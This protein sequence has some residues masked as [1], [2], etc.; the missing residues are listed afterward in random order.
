M[1]PPEVDP[2][3]RLDL[4]D[5]RPGAVTAT[6]TGAPTH[7]VR[8][9][10]AVHGFEPLDD[11]TMVMAR[12]DRE[13]PHYAELAARALRAEG[14]T[15]DI[16]PQ[17]REEIDTEWTWANYPMPWCSREEIREV[18]NDAQ[19]IYDDI[20]SG[21][22]II[23]A[24]AHDG[25]TTVAVGTYR[26]GP[27]IHLHGVNHLRVE[28]GRYDTPVKAIA[29]FERLY[30]DA[31][32]HGPAPAT[33][34]ERDAEQARTPSTPYAADAQA[35]PA[36][37]EPAEA[38]SAS[39]DD[40]EALLKDFLESQGEWECWRTW[41]DDTTHA[42]HESLVLRAEF[43]HE[44]EPTGT[45]WKIAAYESP[46]GERVWHATA[47]T[48]VPVEIMQVVLDSL[49]SAD[50]VE[51]AEGNQISEATIGEATRPLAGAGWKHTIDGRAIRWQA[52]G[53]RAISVQFDAF[54]AHA[55]HSGL[56][57]WTFR[58]GGDANSPQWV[59]HF[60]PRA[61]ASVLQDVAFEVANGLTRQPAP[62][63][64]QGLNALSRNDSVVQ[65]APRAGSARSR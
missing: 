47:S 16:T 3:L 53:D 50:A 15:V 59:L 30:G 52:P 57:A 58:G 27:S 34:T 63:R 7:T 32:R 49:A 42:V 25:W 55:P 4:L 61:A 14:V 18:S 31:V 35:S 39:L 51:I 8:A 36:M 54:A 5:G 9:L 60:S 11:A 33:S 62:P 56:P 28:A 20:R 19:Q 43:I 37:A 38:G 29:E 44:A 2:H 41:S 22:L 45:Q 48:T 6:I 17:L 1:P 21:R 24:H 10:L 65:L 23:H 26:D 40:H 13:E 12:I 46:V 64:P